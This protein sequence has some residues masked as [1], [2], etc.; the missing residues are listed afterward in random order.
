MP[1]APKSPRSAA[2]TPEKLALWSVILDRAEAFLNLEP[3]KWIGGNS[4]LGVRD[5]VSG[6]ITITLVHRAETTDV[7]RHFR[8]SFQEFIG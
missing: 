4:I 8:K 7:I 2:L 3:W 1:R 5:P 6:D